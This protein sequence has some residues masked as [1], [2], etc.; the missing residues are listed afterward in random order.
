[1]TARRLRALGAQVVDAPVGRLS[2]RL[3][4][5][6]LGLKARGAL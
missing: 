1:R 4:D 3:A 6:Y 5:A 2:G